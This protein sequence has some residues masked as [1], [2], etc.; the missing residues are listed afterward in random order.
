MIT[1]DQQAKLDTL[2]GQFEFINELTLD[3]DP[4]VQLIEKA[5]FERTKSKR[6]LEAAVFAAQ[7]EAAVHIDYL[8]KRCIEL[9]SKFGVTV[10]CWAGLHLTLTLPRG[11]Q[12]R[13]WASLDKQ[14]TVFHGFEYTDKS[15]GRLKPTPDSYDTIL[16]AAAKWVGSSVQI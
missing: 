13:I 4:L 6:E 1:A 15:F 12:F 9:F 10:S 11:F 16:T 8:A 2:K 3:P 7:A 14:D 5:I